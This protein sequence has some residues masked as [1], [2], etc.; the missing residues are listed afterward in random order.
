MTGKTFGTTAQPLCFWVIYSFMLI[1]AFN[2]YAARVNY[3]LDDVILDDNTQMTGRF[4][5]I[6]I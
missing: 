5:G 1:A 6:S 3:T 4:H 2:V